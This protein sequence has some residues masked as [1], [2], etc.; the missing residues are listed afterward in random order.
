MKKEEVMSN[1]LDSATTESTDT[2][3]DRAAKLVAAACASSSNLVKVVSFEPELLTIPPQ[4]FLFNFKAVG[5]TDD[6]HLRVFRQFLIQLLPNKFTPFLVEDKLP[7]G[8]D[9]VIGPVVH[10]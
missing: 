4:L 6:G 10:Y 8:P 2:P 9:L 5:I 1:V 3:L 7:L